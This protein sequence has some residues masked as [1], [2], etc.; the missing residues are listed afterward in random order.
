MG[1]RDGQI[2]CLAAAG[3]FSLVSFV[4]SIF[5]VGGR[6]EWRGVCIGGWCSNSFVSI[7]YKQ[8]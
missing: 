8:Y 2:K 1:I 6:G 4:L 3:V 5:F 7:Q